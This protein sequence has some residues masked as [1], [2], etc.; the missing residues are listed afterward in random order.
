MISSLRHTARGRNREYPPL[1][2][3]S[4]AVIGSDEFGERGVVAAEHGLGRAVDVVA[5]EPSFKF[6]LKR[7]VANALPEV[8]SGLP[9]PTAIRQLVCLRAYLDYA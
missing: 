2:V 8:V 7:R 3:L 6:R 5:A 4:G 1:A 9:W